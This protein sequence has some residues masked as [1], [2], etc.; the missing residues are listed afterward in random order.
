MVS[1]LRDSKSIVGWQSAG[2]VYGTMWGV[3]YVSLVIECQEG[4]V[5]DDV[6]SC[7]RLEVYEEE[8]RTLTRQV[9]AKT[10]SS[11]A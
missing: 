6:K 4:V 3:R 7:G 5:V 11:I 2:D 8:V 1:G 9:G 10:P